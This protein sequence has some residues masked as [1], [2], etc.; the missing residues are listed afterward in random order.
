MVP[1]MS[2]EEKR[3]ICEPLIMKK[4]E[5]GSGF[6]WKS[7][8]F[9]KLLNYERN[10]YGLLDNVEEVN[11]TPREFSPKRINY[12]ELANYCD[13][14]HTTINNRVFHN[15]DVRVGIVNSDGSF[16]TMIPDCLSKVTN[17]YK[18][19]DIPG[20]SAY[21]QEINYWNHY[22]SQVK[23]SEPRFLYI[24]AV[25]YIHHYEKVAAED[26]DESIEETEDEDGSKE[27]AEDEID[28]YK[29][30]EHYCLCFACNEMR[31]ELE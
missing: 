29:D 11:L 17:G 25:A 1:G 20:M 8:T 21:Y 13:E 3:K 18:F 26:D 4:L 6:P 5:F 2:Y 22:F 10:R 27:E 12:W 23:E 31:R 19:V 9:V 7:E 15:A 28:D 16:I 14:H 24:A 30:D